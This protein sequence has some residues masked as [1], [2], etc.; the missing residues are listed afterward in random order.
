VKLLIAS[1]A[2]NGHFDG[3]YVGSL[4]QTLVMLRD[5]RVE[6]EWYFLRGVSE[7]S[8]GRDW[9]AS[10]AL[11]NGFDK[12]LFIDADEG[13]RA[14]HV[15]R[16]IRSDKRIIGG[17]YA[18]K[19]VP[20]N[21]NFGVLPQHNDY[22]PEGK[23]PAEA[24]CRFAKEQANPAGE[25][26]IAFLPTGFMLIDCSVFR[27]MQE[28]AP[29]YLTPDPET[30]EDTKCWEF[31]PVG[32]FQDRKDTEDWGFCRFARSCGIGVYLNVFCVVNHFGTFRYAAPRTALPEPEAPA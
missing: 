23:K 8:R 15:L 11:R 30:G 24:F 9:L 13:W 31:F 18:K 10:Y 22:F 27:Q 7:I 29:P 26:E 16:L 28:F 4:I 2:I 12:L 6:V 1:P 21:L 5:E 3:D 19:A 25:V 17:T 14:E 32:V 20:L